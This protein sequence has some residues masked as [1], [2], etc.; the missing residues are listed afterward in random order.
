MLG[1]INGSADLIGF[2]YV[3][4]RIALLA[5]L[6]NFLGVYFLDFNFHFYSA[7]IGIFPLNLG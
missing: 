7:S 1:F 3:W 5:W 6:C 2:P 4:V